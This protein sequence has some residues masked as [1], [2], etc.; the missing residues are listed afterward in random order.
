MWLHYS[1]NMPSLNTSELEELQSYMKCVLN[2]LNMDLQFYV[3]I[4]LF[5]NGGSRHC[6]KYLKSFSGLTSKLL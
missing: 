3:L 6:R 1:S 4:S 5:E 2:G